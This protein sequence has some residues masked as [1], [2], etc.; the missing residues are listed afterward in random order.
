MMSY[1]DHEIETA[2][3]ER[4]REVQF[5]K[6]Q[7][8][9]HVAY[10]FNRFYQRKFQEHGVALEAIQSLDDMTRLPFSYKREFQEDQEQNPP[11]GTNLSEQ[12]ENYIRYHQIESERGV[13]LHGIIS[14]YFW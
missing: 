9:L 1:F 13:G 3:L 11:F 7:E 12:L 8:V 5:Q 2:P 10:R 4:L 6:L 14:K